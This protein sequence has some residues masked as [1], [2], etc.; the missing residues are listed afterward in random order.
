MNTNTEHCALEHMGR[1]NL[2][3]SVCVAADW[4]TPKHPSSGTQFITPVEWLRAY[5]LRVKQ[6]DF[7]LVV[8]VCVAQTERLQPVPLQPLAAAAPHDSRDFNEM[9]AVGDIKIQYWPTRASG[10]SG[11]A[12]KQ[13]NDR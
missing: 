12:S 3:R 7:L 8:S 5:L 6:L 2:R 9:I 4:M 13:A 10:Q 11:G 1:Q